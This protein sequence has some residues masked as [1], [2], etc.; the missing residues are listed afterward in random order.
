MAALRAIDSIG[1]ETRAALEWSIVANGDA[2][3]GLELPRPS[4]VR[5]TCARMSARRRSGWTRR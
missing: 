5:G 1:D 4:A 3:L 2:R